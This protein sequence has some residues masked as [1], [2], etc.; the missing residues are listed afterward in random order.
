MSKCGVKLGLYT[1]Q[2]ILLFKKSIPMSK[3]MS[4]SLNNQNDYAYYL[5]MHSH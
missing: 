3:S 5:G 2:W 1:T 4:M